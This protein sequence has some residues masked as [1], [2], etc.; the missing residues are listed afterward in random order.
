MKPTA[1]ANSAGGAIGPTLPDLKGPS[2]LVSTYTA[3]LAGLLTR[4]K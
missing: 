4:E 1:P 3:R 2:R